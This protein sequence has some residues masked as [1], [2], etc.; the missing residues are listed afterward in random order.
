MVKLLLQSHCSV[1]LSLNQTVEL[2]I[3]AKSN[4]FMSQTII[5]YVNI[6]GEK[7][8]GLLWG[9]GLDKTTYILLLVFEDNW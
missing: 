8:T 6:A 4:S 3:T 7:A 1:E 5:T 2:S 9:G